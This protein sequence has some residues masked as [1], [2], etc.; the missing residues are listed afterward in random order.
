[1]ELFIAMFLFSLLMVSVVYSNL[2]VEKF[3]KKWQDDNRFY[4]EGAYLLSILTRDLKPALG[5]ARTDSTTF[6]IYGLSTDTIKYKLTNGDLVRNGR[7]L[8][9]HDAAIQMFK[10]DRTDFEKST[11]D[12]ILIEGQ[13]N[14][15]E[16]LATVEIRLK[17]KKLE[18]SFIRNVRMKDA[19]QIY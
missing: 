7:V 11:P 13:E 12:S 10:I 5:F 3:L 8:N 17:Y 9:S 16:S 14:F 18:E 19:C 4:E 6:L 15:R 1:M 2:F